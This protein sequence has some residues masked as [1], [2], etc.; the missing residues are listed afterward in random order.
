MTEGRIQPRGAVVMTSIS[1]PNPVMRKIAGDCSERGMPFILVGDTKSPTEF[2]LN[3]C[4]YYSID[5]QAGSGLRLDRSCP[6]RHYARKNIGYLIAMRENIDFIVETDDDNMPSPQFYEPLA[7]DANYEAVAESGWINAYAL[8]DDRLIWPRGFPLDE[9]QKPA[10]QVEAGRAAQVPIQQGL[11]DENPDVDAIYRLL[12]PLSFDFA[13]QRRV[14]FGKGAWCPFN[15]QN[16]VFFREA[17]PLL[18]LPAH[19]SFRM[20]DIWR[21]FVAQR[22]AWANGWSILFRE[23][24]VVQDRNEHDLMRDF[25]D[26]ISGYEGNRDIAERLDALALGGTTASMGDDLRACYDTLIAA[27]HVGKKEAAL[28]EDWLADI[29]DIAAAAD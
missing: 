15:S 5:R 13:R 9:I 29:A 16:T 25:S 12:L 11:A 6:T 10:P 22:I 20:T 1:P 14:A 24:T 8:F 26:E 19:C 7:Q 3:G 23:A 17:F 27:G 4:D 28:L 2:E 21:S 18:Y